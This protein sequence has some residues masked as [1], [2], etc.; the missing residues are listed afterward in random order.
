M[1]HRRH[2]AL[3]IALGGALDSQP[4]QAES[5]QVTIG[6]LQYF[7]GGDKSEEWRYRCARGKDFVAHTAT[8]A[9]AGT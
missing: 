7:S 1:L 5:A 9:G 6:N 3:S 8:G 4:M 2:I